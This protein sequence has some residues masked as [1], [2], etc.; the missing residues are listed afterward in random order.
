MTHWYMFMPAST[1]TCVHVYAA[2]SHSVFHMTRYG[3]LFW[4]FHFITLHCFAYTQITNTFTYVYFIETSIQRRLAF[5]LLFGDT[6]PYILVFVRVRVFSIRILY[7]S[8]GYEFSVWNVWNVLLNESKFIIFSLCHV[9]PNRNCCLDQSEY[10]LL[11]IRLFF[12]CADF[13][14]KAL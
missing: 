11:I 9:Y 4:T 13:Q 7:R 3:I 12:V 1:W 5:I 10:F 2:C 6:I 14:K 8:C